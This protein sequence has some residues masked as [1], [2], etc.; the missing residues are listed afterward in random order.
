MPFTQSMIIKTVGNSYCIWMPRNWG[1][2]K[3]DMLHIEMTIGSKVYHHTAPA[4]K[5][6]SIFVTLPK[7]WPLH[8]GDVYD[9]RVNYANVP[10]RAE[11]DD[12][13]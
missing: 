13:S 4:Q 9:V 11:D 5:N 10:K 6:S 2:Q 1:I 7:F 12:N 3:G 8:A